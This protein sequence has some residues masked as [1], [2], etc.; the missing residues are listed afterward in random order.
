MY[1]DIRWRRNRYGVIY[2]LLLLLFIFYIDVICSTHDGKQ[3]QQQQQQQHQYD[4]HSDGSYG[5]RLKLKYRDEDDGL[6]FKVVQFT[7]LHYGEN[8]GDDIA[9]NNLQ[10]TIL[11]LESPVDLVVF[12]G[13]MISGE[14]L[15][16]QHDISAYNNAWSLMTEP[17]I[18]RN[19]P[20]AIILGSQDAHGLLNAHELLD[21][22]QKYNQSLT[23]HGPRDI[24]GDSNYVLEIYA[25]DTTESPL[26]L[27]YLFD[28]DTKGCGNREWGCIHKDQIDWYK[29][30]SDTYSKN[31]SNSSTTA[32]AFVHVPPSEALQLWNHNQVYG[33]LEDNNGCCCFETDHTAETGKDKNKQQGLVD[34]MIER[35]DVKGLYFGGDHQNDFHGDF[36]GIDLGYGRKSGFASYNP[37]KLHGARVILLQ[38]QPQ[39]QRVEI[40]TWIR[41]ISGAR[42]NQT[43]HRPNLLDHQFTGCCKKGGDPYR[44][45]KITPIV[46]IF[47]L[48]LLFIIFWQNKKPR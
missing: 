24:S 20:W 46:L 16:F 4:S 1:I 9:N 17:L 2:T 7:D 30:I 6:E 15:N 18:K 23:K 29:N 3:Q 33:V 43:E 41:D 39:Q 27:I 26:S 37:N 19:I 38:Q 14:H 35:G 47:T 42:D 28:S 13:D 11:T 44:A 10:N 34:S 12:S 21:F 36:N 45:L 5:E 22:D 40:K 32:L 48:V 31:N 8:D 25:N